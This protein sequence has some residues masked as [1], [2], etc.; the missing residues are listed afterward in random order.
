MTGLRWADASPF[1]S[2]AVAND[3]DADFQ[4]AYSARIKKQGEASMRTPPPCCGRYGTRPYHSTNQLGSANTV[5]DPPSSVYW[6][7]SL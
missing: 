5:S 7:S 3:F 6:F 1:P 2:Q 4:D